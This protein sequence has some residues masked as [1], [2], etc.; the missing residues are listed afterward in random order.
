MSQD[1]TPNQNKE[2]LTYAQPDDGGEDG[3]SEGFLTLLAKQEAVRSQKVPG[4]RTVLVVLSA[5]GVVFDV[6]ALR[7]KILLSYP[8]A[9]VFF[10][11]TD[12]KSIGAASPDQLDLL[13]D[14]TGPGARQG[15]FY[16]KKLRRMSR[17]AVGRNAGFFRRRIY[18]RVFDEVALQK[19]I[20]TEKLSKER[21]VQK[22]VLALAGIPFVQGGDTPADRG[23]SIALELPPLKRL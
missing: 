13:I 12:G 3:Q 5:A 23:K 14:F 16:A 2:S 4:V 17:V 21:R 18:D 15:L 1:K 10:R 11:T 20:P 9:A 8:E 6:E 22:E 7:Q 19:N